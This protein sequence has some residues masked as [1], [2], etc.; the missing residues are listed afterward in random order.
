VLGYRS[1]MLRLRVIVCSVL[2]LS[3]VAG[4][5][6]ADS[7]PNVITGSVIKVLP[8]LMDTN[9]EVAPSPSLFDR[10]AYQAYLLDH[11][12]QISGVRFEICWKA[13]HA[14]GASLKLR[15]ELRGVAASGLPTQTALEQTIMPKWFHRWTSLT[16]NGPGYKNFGKVAAWRT[17]LWSGNQLLGEQQS[18]LWSPP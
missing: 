14:R 5:V 1:V 3:A 15:V 8:L 18:F 7:N 17:T 13:R 6:R 11:T 16:L 9:D 10:D 2:F 4:H 12:N